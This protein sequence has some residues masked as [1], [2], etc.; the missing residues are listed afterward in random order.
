ML[1][2]DPSIRSR[3]ADIALSDIAVPSDYMRSLQQAVVDQ[4][5]ESFEKEGQREAIVVRSAPGA[6]DI[7]YWLVRGRHRLEAARKLGW[8]SIRALVVEGLDA[9]EAQLAQIDENLVHGKLSPTETA[10]NRKARKAIKRGARPS[11]GGTER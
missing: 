10:A 4:I 6:I 5:A 2:K 1:N 7:A 8:D 3:G 9:D 11:A